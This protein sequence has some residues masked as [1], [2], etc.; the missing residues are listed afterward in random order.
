[1]LSSYTQK[2]LQKMTGYSQSKPE[3]AGLPKIHVDYVAS[4]V[5]TLYEKLR[6]VIDFQ[7]EHLLRKNAIE[8]V[9]KRRLLLSHNPEELAEPL[10][11]ELIRGGYF[12]NDQ[13][14]ENKIEKVKK[15]L[16]KYIYLLDSIPPTSR[17]KIELE[18][19]IQG[20]TACEIEETLLPPQ[21]ENALLEYMIETM[22]ERIKITN[23]IPENEKD[24]QIF[25]ACQKA[26][27]KSDQTLISYR[28]LNY[29]WP[30]WK[31]IRTEQ[32]PVISKEIPL[33]KGKIDK[34][35][36]SSIGKKIFK[37]ISHHTAPFLVIGDVVSENPSEAL[38]FFEEP[39]ILE[40]KLL[41]AYNKRHKNCKAK[42]RRSGTRSVISIFLSKVVL[43][44]LIEIP[45]DIYITKKFALPN[46]GINLLLPPFLMFL[47]VAS[48][49]APRP[50]NT[51][52]VVMEA[53]GAIKTTRQPEVYPI[54]LPKKRGMILNVILTLVY[55][56]VSIGVFL[57]MIEGLLKI[58]FSIL[59][60]VIF[61]I[62]FCLIAFSGIK[63]QQWVRELKIGEEKE[64][65]RAF[66]LDLFF[67]PFV[68][69]GRWLS[70]QFQKYNIL[71]LLL[72]LFFEA[73]L[74]TF[75]EFLESWRRYIKEKKEEME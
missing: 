20:L 34:E 17:Q 22:R 61:F 13:I 43:T 29:H 33:L 15:V 71:I 5:A 32:L 3:E 23:Q 1:M 60:I 40:Q 39:E 21:K 16:E 44:F 41:N 2:Y 7:E 6:Q 64:G 58:N 11:Y 25:I 47:I 52:R 66:L 69:A 68:R 26:L 73:P 12:P 37:T 38:K 24:I 10:I 8:R 45:F 48:I 51:P 56:I 14:P 67:L 49:R 18:L 70:V 31:E 50:E 57:A 30:E 53:I 46:L 65:I 62:F 42:I 9:L 27:L 72:N 28:L 35:I 54:Q 63:T 19:W 36:T 74:Q 55:S 59:S 4:R 75:F